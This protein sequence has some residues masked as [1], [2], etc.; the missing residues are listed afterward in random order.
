MSEEQNPLEYG[1]K[2]FKRY[3]QAGGVYFVAYCV[4]D[5][6]EDNQ[7]ANLEHYALGS[8]PLG[9]LSALVSELAA[10]Q[11]LADVADE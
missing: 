10:G 9:A 6:S 11:T 7:Y 2:V 5:V 4:E 3:N 8:T 1:F